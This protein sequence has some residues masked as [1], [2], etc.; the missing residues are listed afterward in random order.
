MTGSIIL[1]NIMKNLESFIMTNRI[2]DENLNIISNISAATMHE[3]L[4]KIGALPAYLKPISKGMKICGRALP[5]KGPS[6]CNLWLHRGI[7]KAQPN[8][9]II[10]NVG[11]DREYGYWGDIMGTGAKIRGISGLVIDGY[12]RDQVELE[13]MRFSVFA[14]GLSIRGTSKKFEEKGTIGKTITIGKINIE[15]GDLILG[16]N[17]GVV[18]IPYEQVEEGIAKSIERENKETATKNRLLNGETSL[19]IYGWSEG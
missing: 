5:V 16:D 9:V 17:D 7:A 11:D 14:A 10:A 2:S 13:E 12:V 3:A 19:Q 15:H 4:G 18:I 8:D 1:V 6:G